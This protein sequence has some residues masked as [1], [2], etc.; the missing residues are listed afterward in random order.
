M[1]AE[2][3]ETTRAFFIGISPFEWEFRYIAL[4]VVCITLAILALLRPL[5]GRVKRTHPNAD[6]FSPAKS[7]ARA[8]RRHRL[9]AALS[10][11][12][13]VGSIAIAVGKPETV[14]MVSLDHPPVA[15]Y[16][17]VV[18][19]SG[20]IGSSPG[21]LTV[22][23]RYIEA[24]VETARTANE[25]GQFAPAIGV[26]YFSSTPLLT[27]SPTRDYDMLWQRIQDFKP[28]STTG[29]FGAAV[30]G[31]SARAV[32]AG[33]GTEP[34]PALLDAVVRLLIKSDPSLFPVLDDLRRSE[35]LMSGGGPLLLDAEV[36]EQFCAAAAGNRIV[37][38]T[39]LDYTRNDGIVAPDRV[40]TLAARA[41]LPVD[42]IGTGGQLWPELISVVEESGGH[43]NSFSMRLS[44]Q[45]IPEVI[46]EAMAE[47][48]RATPSSVHEDRE[49]RD[50]L[51]IAVCAAVALV[52][53]AL[54]VYLR[55]RRPS[56]GW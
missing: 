25:A 41:C 29:G 40:M 9:W 39:D 24:V 21:D 30:Q 55:I 16:S 49:Q 19:V 35:V 52:A 22:I 2:L 20:S 51:P 14:H 50:D 18:D 53:L 32:G 27:I 6:F 46:A 1:Y 43:A 15:N 8:L 48:E 42:V 5:R 33:S 54:L 4:L 3:L 44:K 47:L 34:G 26:A 12:L 38:I 10:S 28:G 37:F 11:A 17:L 13:L 31:P 56:P 45:R 36:R 23:T 7:E